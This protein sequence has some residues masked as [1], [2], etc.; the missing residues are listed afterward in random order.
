[1]RNSS[2]TEVRGVGSPLAKHFFINP[3]EGDV[4]ELCICLARVVG[5]VSPT[6]PQTSKEGS[7]CTPKFWQGASQA[8]A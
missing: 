1:M 5:P 7:E 4:F 6:S 2:A 8:Q 3:G